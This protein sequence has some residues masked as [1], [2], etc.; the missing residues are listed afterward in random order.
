MPSGTSQNLY[1]PTDQVLEK[2]DLVKE[3]LSRMLP[4]C[5]SVSTQHD[6]SQVTTIKVAI[7]IGYKLR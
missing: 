2:L 4:S 5:C 6:S 1:L 3:G 7:S